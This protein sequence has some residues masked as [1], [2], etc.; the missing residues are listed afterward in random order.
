MQWHRRIATILLR[1]AGL[2]SLLALAAIVL[3]MTYAF[4][5][6]GRFVHPGAGGS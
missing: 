2:V 6:F 1:L 5:W 3:W 4:L